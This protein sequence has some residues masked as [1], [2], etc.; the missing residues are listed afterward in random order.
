[1]NC[2][3]ERLVG[4]LACAFGKHAYEVVQ[5]FGDGSARIGCPRCRREW[6]MNCRT[7]SLIP[8]DF[9]LQSMYRNIMGK[10]I[11]NPRWYPPNAGVDR[12]EKAT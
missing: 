5:D 7:R 1:M 9:E 12:Q 2:K 11:V 8:W 6:G 4:H 10:R 3:L